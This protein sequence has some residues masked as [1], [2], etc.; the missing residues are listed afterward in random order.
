M[1]AHE[2]YESDDDLYPFHVDRRPNAFTYLVGW[3]ERGR[4]VVKVG[5]AGRPARWRH[6]VSRG[7]KPLLVFEAR[8]MVALD[9]ESRMHDALVRA[10]PLA[11][12]EKADAAHLLGPSCGGWRETYEA[13]HFIVKAF[14]RGEIRALVQGR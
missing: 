11:F 10:Y 8:S 2:L 5:F 1:L 12:R 9:L 3:N 7:A 14:M 4:E 13:P 6:F